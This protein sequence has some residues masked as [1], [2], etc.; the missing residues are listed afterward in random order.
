[1]SQQ[2]IRVVRRIYQE[3]ARGNFGAVLEVLAAD[4]E[5]ETYMPDSAETVT[6][7]GTDALGAF[8]REWFGQWE[9]YRAVGDEFR[10]VGDDT[11]LVLGRQ[12]GIGRESGVEVESPGFTVWTFRAGK[13]VKLSAHYDRQQALRAAGITE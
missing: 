10:S 4:V 3:L 12:L 1:M 7:R 5:F 8:M 11:V 9:R 6:V 2:N 13:V